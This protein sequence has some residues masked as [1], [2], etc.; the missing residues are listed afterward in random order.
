MKISAELTLAVIA[1]VDLCLKYEH[2]CHQTVL[3]W[4]CVLSCS[5]L[6]RLTDLLRYGTQIKKAQTNLINADSAV[7][8]LLLRLENALLRFNQQLHFTQHIKHL[9]DQE[10][11]SVYDKTLCTIQNKLD[12]VKTALQSISQPDDSNATKRIKYVWQ[13]DGLED[14]VR[15]L[16]VWL[17]LTDQSWFLF[18]TILSPGMDAALTAENS[19][20]LRLIPS[21]SVIRSSVATASIP[22]V[23]PAIPNC[24][25]PTAKLRRWR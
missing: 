9:M 2:P 5:I 7:S 16:D 17:A 13:K 12:L 22:R 21:A 1:T 15:E 11:Q 23:K 19:N 18:M 3:S 24:C 4:R 10:H 14:A 20:T 25:S 8:E 6:E